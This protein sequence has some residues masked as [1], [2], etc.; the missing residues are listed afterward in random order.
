MLP[1]I[2]HGLV[3]SVNSSVGLNKLEAGMPALFVSKHLVELW[4]H[5]V[6]R[7]ACNSIGLPAG[8]KCGG[9]VAAT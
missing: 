9:M 1:G 2:P 4:F 8:S 3:R 7:G 6:F 5:R